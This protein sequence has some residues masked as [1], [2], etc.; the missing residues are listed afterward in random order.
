MKVK[1]E[2]KGIKKGKSLERKTKMES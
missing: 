1:E 2:M